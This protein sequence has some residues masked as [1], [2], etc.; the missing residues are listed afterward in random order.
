M[1]KFFAAYLVEHGSVSV[2]YKRL[3][4]AKRKFLEV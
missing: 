2:H 1:S 4:A 3:T